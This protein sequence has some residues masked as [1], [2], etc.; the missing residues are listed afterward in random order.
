VTEADGTGPA[1]AF[2]DAAR[3]WPEREF[4]VVPGES[5]AER[6]TYG[7]VAAHVAPLAA[8]YAAAGYGHGHRV[9]LLLENRAEFFRHFLAL[10][11]LGVSVVPVNPFYRREEM[12]YLVAHSEAVLVVALPERLADARAAATLADPAPPTMGPDDPP[13]PARTRPPKSGAPGPASE[14]ALLYTSGTTGRPKG[15]LL[16]HEYFARTGAWYASRGDL[17]TILP[18]AERILTPLPLF[19]MNALAVSLM[20][21]MLTGNTLVQLDRFH[22]KTWWR[23]VAETEATI[24]HYLGVM[25]ALLMAAAADPFERRHGVKFGFGANTD[26]A[27]HKAFEDRFG[28]PLLEAWGMT[29]TG[30]G[31]CTLDCR[32]DRVP[33]LRGMGRAE[34]C[35]AMLRDHEGRAIDGPGTG[36][37]FVRTSA[38]APR[39][40]FFDGYLKDQ[41]ATDAAWA[42]GWFDTGDIVRRAADGRLYFVDRAKNIIRRAGENIAALEVD[43]CLVD[44]P[45]VA[46]VAVVAARDELREEEVM[47]CVVPK[48]GR[49]PDRALAEDIQAWC[50]ARLAYFKAPGW[51]LFLDALPVTATNKVQKGSL[52]ALGADPRALPLAFDL[53]AGKKPRR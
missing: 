30:G 37:F 13:P 50:L 49:A 20:G 6:F 9:A 39:R 11:S 44:H 1:A 3:R 35:E 42:T 53:R 40:G 33:G 34:T 26:P 38:E 32:T 52:A 17:A 8:A 23:T 51:V 16:S 18:G 2:A 43:S 46:E 14:C 45:A 21:A 41:A 12:G 24:V 31:A 29:E 48:P 5:G 36:R 7:A 10:A 27:Q 15:C 25:P 28:F 19:H 4:L 22:P 47:A